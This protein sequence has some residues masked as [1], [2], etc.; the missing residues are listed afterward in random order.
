MQ[1]V[2]WHLIFSVHVSMGWAWTFIDKKKCY[3]PSHHFFLIAC[4]PKSFI[5]TADTTYIP[6][7]FMGTAVRQPF[8]KTIWEQY[9]LTNHA[10]GTGGSRFLKMKTI[11]D[12][13]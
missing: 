10:F 12:S 6:K 2:S 11:M 8:P 1:F 5:G 9:T 13:W 4:I 3:A 7:S